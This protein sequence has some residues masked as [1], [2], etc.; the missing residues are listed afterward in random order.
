[1]FPRETG[2]ILGE[3]DATAIPPARNSKPASSL[4]DDELPARLERV[5]RWNAAVLVDHANRDV[6]GIGGHL[7]TY[8]S[9]STLFSIGWDYFFRGR[10]HP[11]GGDHVFFQGHASPGVYARAYAEGRLTAE[12]LAAFRQESKGGLSSYPH[13]RLMPSFWE[14]PTVSMGLGPIAA[15]EQARFD[16]YLAQR[17]LRDTS[18]QRTWAFLGDG[19]CDEPETLGL[20]RQAGR[21]GLSNLVFVVSCNLQRLDG[22]ANG[23]GSTIRELAQLFAG[24]NWRVVRL[25]WG[26]EWDELFAAEPRLGWHIAGMN[27]GDLQRLAAHVAPDDP[28]LLAERAAHVRAELFGPFAHLV[29]DRSDADVVA[30]AS[31]VGGQDRAAVHAAYQEACSPDPRPTVV[32]ARTVKGAFFPHAGRNAAHQIKKL[33]PAEFAAFAENL[34]LALT[35]A[36]RALVMAGT[37][38]LVDPDDETR[39]WLAERVA[40]HGAI[41]SRRPSPPLVLDPAAING[42]GELDAGSRKAVSTTGALTRALTSLVRDEHVVPVLCDEGRTFGYDPMYAKIGV[43]SARPVTYTAVDA[44]LPL[45]Y[46][47]DQA[48]QVIQAGISEAAAMGTFQAVGTA[49]ATHGLAM[50]PVY[51]FYS[52]FGLQRTGDLVWQSADARARGILVGATAGRTTLH[53]EGLQHQDGHSLAW[54]M[55]VPHLNAYDCAYSYELA[56]V[57]RWQ[58]ARYETGA[59]EM[60]YLVAYNEAWEQPAR[61]AGVSDAD[62]AAGAYVLA[63][64]TASGPAVC[65]LASGPAVHAALAAHDELNRLGVAATVI[66][67]TS[68]KALWLD[69]LDAKRA[70]R[71]GTP[72]VPLV[73]TLL[74]G[75]GPA[76]AVSDWTNLLP[77]SIAPYCP[78]GLD[79]LGTDG[80]GRSD[81]RDALREHFAVTSSHVLA[82]ALAATGELPGAAQA[83]LAALRP[84]FAGPGSHRADA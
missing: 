58:L 53:G 10:T 43:F 18:S 2:A 64:P 16:R 82:A 83:R 65:L 28:T 32:L 23:S 63:E 56:S 40:T 34:G 33:S 39:A 54:A 79:T 75:R 76:V 15:I 37:P 62:I 60:L 59:E 7:S 8:A 3:L 61:P 57:L 74:S 29:A 44:A 78:H 19:E 21:D 17:S 31:C 12:Q 35:A 30:L 49:G 46:R 70:T 42:L 47:E 6:D 24:A 77:S 1:V 45:R 50:L 36:E 51:T 55:N 38:P 5:V 14:F 9:S 26:H 52:M 81:G 41:P 20:I 22:P 80:F 48:G 71:A 73:T 25:W 84:L 13:P 4:A 66:A 11:S 69:A 27:D 72:T 68:Y 67:V